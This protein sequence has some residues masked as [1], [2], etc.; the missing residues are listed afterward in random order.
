[1]YFFFFKQFIRCIIYIQS[2]SHNARINNGCI[3]TQ[4]WRKKRSNKVPVC[5][6]AYNL[7]LSAWVH[8]TT[9]KQIQNFNIQKIVKKFQFK[10]YF[11]KQFFPPIFYFKPEC[12]IWLERLSSWHIFIF[13]LLRIK[14]IY[15]SLPPHLSYSW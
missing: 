4:K 13:T 15:G 11:S 7:V 6:I 1:M 8:F 14:R 10:I 5:N 12:L 3:H 2:K 9:C